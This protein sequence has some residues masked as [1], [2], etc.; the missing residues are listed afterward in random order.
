MLGPLFFAMLGQG[1]LDQPVQK[2]AITHAGGFPH[3]RIHAD[4][5]ES[6][7]R[8]DFVEENAADGAAFRSF[9]LANARLNHPTLGRLHL[10]DRSAL[11]LPDPSRLLKGRVFGPPSHD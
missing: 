6:W 8:V 1:Q 11:R 2:L 9:V 10:L 4:R 5:G 7:N 3:F